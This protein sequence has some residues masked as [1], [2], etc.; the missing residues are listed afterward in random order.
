MTLFNR[1]SL[2]GTFLIFGTLAGCGGGGGGSSPGVPSGGSVASSEPTWTAGNYLTPDHFA[3]R[4]AVPR[5]GPD[6]QTGKPYP[7]RKGSVRWENHW[8]RAWEHA[9]YLWYNEL[10]DLNPASYATTAAYF[11]ADRPLPS[12]PPGRPR[13]NST[14]PIRRISG[15]PL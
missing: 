15:R 14:S 6:P 1:L 2:L 10:P 7:D 4:C 11:K 12:R 13:T 5:T 9:Y 8:I 3:A